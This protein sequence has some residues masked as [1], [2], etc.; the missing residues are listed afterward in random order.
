MLSVKDINLLQAQNDGLLK[1]NKDLQA[2]NLRLKQKI[3][4]I[5]TCLDDFA[6]K[7][8]DYGKYKDVLEVRS[9]DEN[10]YHWGEEQA[11][12]GTDMDELEDLLRDF[13]E[14]TWEVNNDKV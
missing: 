12:W 13:I 6:N 9:E 10:G 4:A 14:F 8:D 1:Q 2:E 5:K 7:F 3:G 11:I